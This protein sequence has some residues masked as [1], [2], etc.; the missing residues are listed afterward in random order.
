MN[1]TSTGYR[2]KRKM[3]G[4]SLKK[5]NFLKEIYG[6]LNIIWHLKQVT[7]MKRNKRIVVFTPMYRQVI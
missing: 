7:L 3:G 1:F 5:V 6:Y 4:K 2:G